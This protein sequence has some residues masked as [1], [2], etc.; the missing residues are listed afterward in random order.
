MEIKVSTTIDAPIDAVWT[1]LAGDFAQAS[2]WMSQVPVS[3]PI[4]GEGPDGAPVAGRVCEL[5]PKGP[6]G[7][8]AHEEILEFDAKGHRLV[9]NVTPKNTPP[10]FPVKYSQ[11]TFSLE[12]LPFG[13]TRVDI[14]AMP[15]LNVLGAVLK[16]VLRGKLTASF[17]EIL[18]DLKTHMEDQ[19]AL[20]A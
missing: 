9:L 17:A 6:N 12:S 4:P 7:I 3:Y 20:A 14:H 18:A 8:I 16:P 1:V 5:S 2:N 19:T 15:H 13:Q 11:T 10:G